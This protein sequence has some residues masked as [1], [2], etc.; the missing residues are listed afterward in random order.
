MHYLVGGLRISIETSS[1]TPGPR[2]HIVNFITALQNL[3]QDPQI[4]VASEQKGLTRFARVGE[5]AAQTAS[6]ARLLAMDLI[7][8]SAASIASAT[9]YVQTRRAS[10][11][12]IYERASVLQS[13]SS[14]HRSRRRAIRVIESNGIM[15]RETAADRNA[16]GSPRLAELIERR[17]YRSAHLVV[18]VS[19]ALA[20]EI[21]RFAGIDRRR[22]LTLPNAIPAAT[23]AV[24]L[25]P[26]TKRV[27]IGFAGAVVAWQHLDRL[28]WAV[29]NEN[30]RRAN[31]NRIGIEILGD[32][33]ELHRLQ[34]LAHDLRCPLTTL[35][36]VPTTEVY[37][38]M[39]TWSAGYAGHQQS[40]SRDMYHSPLK[41]YEYAGFALPTI[42]T[43]SADA[44]LLMRDGLPSLIVETDEHLALAVASIRPIYLKQ[45]DRQSLRERLYAIHSWEARAQVFLDAV[46]QCRGNVASDYRRDGPVPGTAGGKQ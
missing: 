6:P 34:R 37:Q 27:T 40:S 11:D 5:G 19:D 43:P 20:E 1:S 4:F 28:I 13:L 2:S 21:V 39:A 17:S 30:A 32:G 3:G 14:F 26:A 12:I 31:A 18:A 23:M 44:H 7:R 41:L 42:C 15:S 25:A 24:T 38:R 16:L 8:L 36:R 33:P 45:S 10:A 46:G 35:G 22:I 9:L 29:A